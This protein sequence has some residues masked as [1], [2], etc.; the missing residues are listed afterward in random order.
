MNVMKNG[1]G[2]GAI[3]CVENKQQ[4]TIE[5]GSR[6]LIVVTDN[7]AVRSKYQRHHPEQIEKLE[8]FSIYNIYYYCTYI[9]RS[10]IY[11]L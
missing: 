1:S 3:E 6:S 9:Y 4:L 5:E 2:S 7:T 8:R 10:S 11:S